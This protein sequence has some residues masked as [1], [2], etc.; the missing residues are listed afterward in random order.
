MSV[1]DDT[2]EDAQRQEDCRFS[3]AILGGILILLN[4]LDLLLTLPILNRFGSEKEKNPVARKVYERF[5]SKGLIALKVAGAGDAIRR[6]RN[7]QRLA[8]KLNIIMYVLVVINNALTV[9]LL[10][11]LSTVGWTED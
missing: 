7:D 5:G 8:L 1:T 4:I 11:I 9:V 2:G 10:W 3:T 6:V